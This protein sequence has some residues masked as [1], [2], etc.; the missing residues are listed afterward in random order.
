MSPPTRIRRAG[1]AIAAI[2]LGFITTATIVTPAL[3]VAHN[4]VQAI[5]TAAPAIVDTVTGTAVTATEVVVNEA[6]NIVATISMAAPAITVL[7]FA[8][9]FVMAPTARRNR[10]TGVTARKNRAIAGTRG[11]MPTINGFHDTGPTP[12]GDWTITDDALHEWLDHGT[13]DLLTAGKHKDERT[14]ILTG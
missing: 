13:D 4:A 14:L 1:V 10:L 6:T 2:C 12:G 7:A 5:D 3:S 8:V 11:I 9:M